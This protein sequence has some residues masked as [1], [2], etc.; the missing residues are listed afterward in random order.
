MI[1]WRWKDNLLSLVY[2]DR[3]FLCQHIIS[4]HG[5]ASP[6]ECVAEQTDLERTDYC[7]DCYEEVCGDLIDRCCTCGATTNVNNPFGMRCRLCRDLRLYFDRAVAIGDYRGLLQQ[8]VVQMK[9]Q[10]NDTTA[11][12]FG[13]LLAGMLDKFDVPENIDLIVPVPTHWT[14]RLQRKGYHG[15]ALVAEGIR[16]QTGWKLAAGTLKQRRRTKKQG[17]LSIRQRYQ[18]VKTAF[19]A[20]P[21]QFGKGRRNSLQDMQVLLVDDVMTSGATVS[22]AGRALIQAGAQRVFVAVVARGAGV[23]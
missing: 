21:K 11:I 6:M 20:T 12:Q 5:G 15:S 17:T 14:R 4:Q 1:N 23:S 19:T 10:W 3:C 2:P 8:K 13:K 18:N 9:R 16:R 7:R 22:E